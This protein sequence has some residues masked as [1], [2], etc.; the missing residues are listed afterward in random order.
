[1]AKKDVLLFESEASV[2][3]TTVATFLRNLA[4]ELEDNQ[5]TLFS[6]LEE[7][8]VTIPDVVM[9]DLKVEKESKHNETKHS[10]EIEL[11]WTEENMSEMSAEV[12]HRHLLRTQA[13]PTQEEMM[14]DRHLADR[15]PI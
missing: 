8:T 9:L 7:L 15:P 1:M 10:L 14:R 11:E 3:V 12:F 13:P 4:D 2:T 5:I 6:D